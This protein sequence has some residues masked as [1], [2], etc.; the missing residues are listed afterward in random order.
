ME[1]QKK[2]TVFLSALPEVSGDE[3]TLNK[4]ERS[5]FDSL[6]NQLKQEDSA[7]DK[8][9]RIA[10]TED[11]MNTNN[12]AGIY[13]NKNDL[14]P[15]FLIKKIRVQNSLVA[16]IQ[17]LRSN[18]LSMF[19]HIKKDRF[20]IGVQTKIKAAFEGHVKPDQMVKIRKRIEKFESI[21]MNCGRTDGYRE[22]D[23]LS[24]G[25]FLYLQV[26]EAITLGRFATEVIYEN[27]EQEDKIFHSFRPVDA[28]TIFKTVKNGEQA[29][30]IRQSGLRQI[31]NLTGV[32][33]DRSKFEN[34]SYSYVQAI[35]GFPKIAFTDKEMLVWNMYPSNDI[36]HNGYPVTPI[37]TCISAISTYLNI[38]TYNR[39]YFQ[40]GRAAKGMLVIK[41]DQ[42]DQK[43]LNM[44]RQEFTASINNATNAF[45]VPVLG[46]SQE[47]NAVWTPMVSSAGDGEF[48]F[49]YDN[50]SRSILTAFMVSPE[51]MPGMGHLAKGTNNKA[52]S[53]SNNS[54]KLTAERDGGL[55]PLIVRMEEFINQKLFP[56][57]DP[58]LAQI[59]TVG[60]TGMDAQSREEEAIRLQQEMPIHMTYNQVLMDVDKKP[61]SVR[62]GGGFPFSE[63]M[64]II[65]DKY[66]SAGELMYEFMK[67]PNA[68]SDPMLKYKRDPFWIQCVTL[69]MQANPAAAKAYFATKP[70]ALEILKTNIQDY[71]DEDGEV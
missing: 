7:K 54:Y 15:D 51:E 17:R 21:L 67:D 38:E 12:W 35:D 19:G 42:V 46:I 56:I 70:F 68:L 23:Q 58:E 60:L 24:F 37:D 69:M 36:N 62:M 59:C 71:L 18:I 34:D 26:G 14:V 45:R 55:R 2:Q 1:E 64:Q 65:M 33:F 10:F 5:A 27:T 40:N 20:D 29:E 63:R 57:I 22:D 41:S 28:A 43:T 25:D 66:L 32:K 31:E 4:A 9:P 49:L 53:E 47:D 50:V 8:A 13:R 39:L 30:S 61:I 11:P 6:L 44:L 16:N 52:L 48:A 3:Q